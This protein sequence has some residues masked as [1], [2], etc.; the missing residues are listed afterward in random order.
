[1]NGGVD[2]VL[3]V[4]GKW[5]DVEVPESPTRQRARKRRMRVRSKTIRRAGR[6]RFAREEN[7]ENSDG[8]RGT[9]TDTKIRE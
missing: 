5:Y 1:M 9:N 4:Y 6:K 2:V 8:E 3:K 7:E